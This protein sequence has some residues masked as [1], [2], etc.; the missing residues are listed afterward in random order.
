MTRLIVWGILIV[1]VVRALWRLAQGVLE[2]AG[3]RRDARELP[4]VALVKDPVCGVFVAPGHA[5][6]LGTGRDARFFCSEKCR[7]A[8]RKRR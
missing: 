7:E 6:V 2:G 5:L 4:G 3:Y 8:W 1:F